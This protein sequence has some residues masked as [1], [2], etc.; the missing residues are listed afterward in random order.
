[1]A[2]VK[3]YYFILFFI[4]KEG[5]KIEKENLLY[6]LHDLVEKVKNPLAE[7][8]KNILDKHK[9]K[10]MIDGVL[11]LLMVVNS[12]EYYAAMQY[13]SKTEAK[14]LNSENEIYYVGKWVKFQQH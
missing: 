13:F 14:V 7:F 3:S 4:D 9:D 12:S 10:K 5:S 2:I 1:M 11:L 6:T 8:D